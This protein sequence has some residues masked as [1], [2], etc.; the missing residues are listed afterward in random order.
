MNTP[1]SRLL[2]GKTYYWKS[3][4]EHE[5]VLKAI[6]AHR[7]VCPRCKAAQDA[8]REFQFRRDGQAEIRATLAELDRRMVDPDP[9]YGVFFCSGDEDGGI[10]RTPRFGANTYA[11]CSQYAEIY[12]DDVR[13]D[14]WFEIPKLVPDEVAAF[15]STLSA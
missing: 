7:S 10:I 2:C 11:N 3:D 8:A 6:S 5:R 12:K 9:S 13:G 4:A 14:C 1:F 15:E